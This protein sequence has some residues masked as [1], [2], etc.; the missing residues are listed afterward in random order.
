[1]GLN[2]NTM[3]IG[4]DGGTGMEG[5]TWWKKDGSD[6]FKIREVLMTDTGFSVRTEDG[7]LINADNLE[8]YIQSDT[9]ITGRE[10]QYV[11]QIDPSQIEG[12]DSTAIVHDDSNPK[13]F[14]SLKY[15][16]PEAKFKQ[17]NRPRM[18]RHEPDPINDPLD[19]QPE[20]YEEPGSQGMNGISCSIIDRVLG[21]FPM[22][23]L[24]TVNINPID[25]VDECFVV[26]TNTLNIRRYEI[27]EYLT[28][29]LV[30]KIM[31]MINEALDFHFNSLGIPSDEPAPDSEKT[32]EE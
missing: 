9:P 7:R 27:K 24:A 3:D 17:D 8:Q 14:G 16:H 32:E 26:L 12:L 2:N 19:A 18:I 22:D 29:R 28:N 6:H 20:Q 11:P 4:I 23:K 15:S 13:P 25:K 5:T 1:M 31:D 21:K 30:D 10:Q